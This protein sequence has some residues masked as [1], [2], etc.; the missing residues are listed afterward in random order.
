V[1]AGLDDIDWAA[2]RHAYGPAGEVP[3]L[4]HGLIDADPAIRDEAVDQMYSAVHHQRSVYDATIA[5]VPFLLEALITPGLPGRRDI[6]DLLASIAYADSWPITAGARDDALVLRARDLI[7]AATA[8]LLPLTTDPD[9]G[10]RAGV[11]PLLTVGGSGA[12]GP[13]LERLGAE[14]D[15]QAT[16]ALLGALARLAVLHADPAITGR[17]LSFAAG[18]ARASTSIAALIAVAAID[19][20]LVPVDGLAGQLESA[21]AELPSPAGFDTDPPITDLTERLGAR[22]PER[23]GIVAQLL[24]SRHTEVIRDA[25]GAASSL[26][27]HWRGDYAELVRL[28][29]GHLTDPDDRS[30]RL[31]RSAVRHWKPLTAPAADVLAGALAALDAEP[32]RDGLPAWMLLDPWRSPCP[33]PVLATLADLGDERALPC[34]FTAL[35]LTGGPSGTEEL[36]SAY[37][38]HAERVMAALMPAISAGRWYNLRAALSAFGPAAAPAVHF[39]LTEPLDEVTATTLGRIG[40]VAGA[41]VPALRAA[42]SGADPRL[43]VRATGALWRI[44]AAPDILTLLT[45]RID[46]PVAALALTE[47]AGMGRA[48]EAAAPYVATFL[49]GADEDGRL[50]V[51]AAIALW[52]IAGDA[53]RALPVLS[54]GWQRHERTRTVIAANVSGELAAG[55]EPLLRNELAERRRSAGTLRTQV[56]DD[57]TLL[58]AI[59]SALDPSER[60][61]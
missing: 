12:A 33:H 3:G 13:L 34:L 27:D 11:P 52:H 38:Q 61:S 19:P 26:V 39:L 49:D 22:I 8:G 15:P 53:E 24:R 29:A 48:A 1:F 10:V 7:A 51:R 36:V 2:L 58:S 46:G 21:C 59:R 57:E 35:E 44:E 40:P 60:S 32:W 4:L 20:A 28:V 37:P 16:R 6:A 25:L 9:Q 17:L 41:A 30:A 47:L 18:A 43:A 42:A 23:T 56:T 14:T 55:L 50:P 5:A 54:A 31:A 45:A